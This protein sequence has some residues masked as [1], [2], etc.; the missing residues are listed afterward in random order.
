MVEVH[1]YPPGREAK[2]KRNAEASRR[3][4]RAKT[5]FA[6]EGGRATAT[7]TKP[8]QPTISPT[9]AA[10]EEILGRQ[11]TFGGLES[12]TDNGRDVDLPQP[13]PGYIPSIYTLPDLPRFSDFLQHERY[14]IDLKSSVQASCPRQPSPL[15]CLRQ[16]LETG[17]KILRG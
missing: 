10:N 14:I 15:Q 12:H 6:G 13:P 11:S 1:G 3:Y 5:Q 17:N 4:R 8:T 16:D 7:T 2:R 9:M